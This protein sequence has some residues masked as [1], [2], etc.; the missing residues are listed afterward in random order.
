ML[1]IHDPYLEQTIKLDEDKKNAV[2]VAFKRYGFR[3]NR[4]KELSKELYGILH[5]KETFQNRQEYGRT[6]LHFLRCMNSGIQ[7]H[8]TGECPRQCHWRLFTAWTFI[9]CR[10]LVDK[11]IEEDHIELRDNE[12]EAK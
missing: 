8:R 1:K 5:V 4:L 9:R 2:R 6:T 3:R 12:I 7:I 10:T 11:P